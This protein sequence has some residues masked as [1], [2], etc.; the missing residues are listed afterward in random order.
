MNTE[1]SGYADL[2]EFLLKAG[3]WAEISKVG[4]SKSKIKGVGFS[5]LDSC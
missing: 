5:H 4:G 1:N 2:T 3:Q